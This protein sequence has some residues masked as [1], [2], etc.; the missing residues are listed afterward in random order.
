MREAWALSI[1]SACCSVAV[2]RNKG[3]DERSDTEAAATDL[4]APFV[5]RLSH[6][7]IVQTL[8][9]SKAKPL[10]PPE[11]EQLTRKA[12]ERALDATR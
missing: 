6:I 12:R 8:Y 3:L 7:E 4:G 11:A 10:S 5:M 9:R 2:A 1:C